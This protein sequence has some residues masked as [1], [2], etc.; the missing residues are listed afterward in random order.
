MYLAM[1]TV[2]FSEALRRVAW[3]VLLVV[4]AMTKTGCNG[5]PN[6]NQGGGGNPSPASIANL[7]PNSGA[8]QSS[9][10]I[11]GANFGATQGTSTVK[12]NGTTATATSWSAASITAAVPSGATTGN[13]VVTVGGVASNGVNF[14]VASGPVIS[15]VSVGS[16]TTTGA[17]VSWTTDVV[18]TSQVEYGTTT[19]YGSLTTLGSTLV[20]SHSVALTGLSTSTLYHY[21]VRSKNSSGIE[22]ISGDFA[23]Q[24]SSVVDTTPPTIAITAPA[25]G[26]TVS[27]SVTVSANAS[28]NV[29]VASVQFFLDGSN[30]GSLLIVGPYSVAWNTATASNGAHTL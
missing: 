20:T 17:I 22:S 27:G 18:A 1:K 9:V 29:G 3:S 26:V 21:R 24:T 16:I 25:N 13:V 28:D 4:L 2:T 7:N 11:M 14:T 5:V 15:G 8:V 6:S 23:F 19:A 30:L 12:F 10:T